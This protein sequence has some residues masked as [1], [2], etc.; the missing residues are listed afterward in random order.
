MSDKFEWE[1]ISYEEGFCITRR[2]K[3]FGGWLVKNE[4][5]DSEADIFAQSESMVFVPDPSHQWSV[6][7]EGL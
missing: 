2:A 3:V 6:D 4:S 5:Y 1:D 7:K